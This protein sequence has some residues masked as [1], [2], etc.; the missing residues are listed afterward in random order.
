M[1]L[2]VFNSKNEDKKH[3]LKHYVKRILFSGVWITALLILMEFLMLIAL[4]Y[5]FAEYSGFIFEAM[6][7][8]GVVV[9]IYIINEKSNPAY[10]IAWIIPIMLFPLVGCMLYLFVKLNFGNLAAKGMLQKNIKETEKYSKTKQVVKADIEA[11]ES[12]FLKVATYIENAGGYPA[13]KNTSMKYY[14]LG[15]YIMEP[16]LEELKKQKN[17]F[18]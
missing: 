14:S 3:T 5:R 15:D 10:K 9:M 4:F 18:L 11:E 8:G 6:V 2:Q 7:I 12:K 17:I 1:K 13:W 16:I